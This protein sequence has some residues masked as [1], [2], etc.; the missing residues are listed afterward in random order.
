MQKGVGF[1]AL[2]AILVQSGESMF[3]WRDEPAGYEMHADD[4]I[5]GVQIRGIHGSRKES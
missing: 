5:G 1:V 3:R 4:L 2:L